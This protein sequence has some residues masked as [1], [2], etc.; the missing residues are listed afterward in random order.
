[1]GLKSV[2]GS[3]NRRSLLAVDPYYMQLGVGVVRCAGTPVRSPASSPSTPHPVAVGSFAAPGR[4]T[5]T[6]G[7]QRVLEYTQASR[8]MFPVRF[9]DCHNVVVHQTADP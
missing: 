1:M 8:A 5:R 6:E 2:A 7:R 4:P 3:Q 9:D